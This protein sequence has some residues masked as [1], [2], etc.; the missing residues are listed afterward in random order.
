MA[1]LCKP[2]DMQKGTEPVVVISYALW[3]RRFGGCRRREQQNHAERQAATIVGIMP[4]GFTYP[5]TLN[6]GR[7]CR[8]NP[9]EEPRDNRYVRSCR[10]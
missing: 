8:L 3:Q 9:A 10:G 2:H 5:A 7:R 1:A 6:C 4:A